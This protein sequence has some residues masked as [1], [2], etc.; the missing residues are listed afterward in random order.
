MRIVICVKEV[1]DPDAVN[2][3]AVAGRLEIGDD[4]KTL[5]QTAIP[6]LINGF[7]EQALEAALRIRDAGVECNISV[8]SIGEDVAWFSRARPIKAWLAASQRPSSRHSIARSKSANAR[9]CSP[10]LSAA[11]P[12]SINSVG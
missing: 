3:Y 10:C 11:I 12:S 2:N 5:T 4:G 6:R 1:M 7:D 9:P 8:L